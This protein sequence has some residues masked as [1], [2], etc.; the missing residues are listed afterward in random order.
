MCF[1]LLFAVML[2]S[3]LAVKLK[4]CNVENADIVPYHTS[5]QVFHKNVDLLL[6]YEKL[7]QTF[8]ITCFG[9][10][11]LVWKIPLIT[12]MLVEACLP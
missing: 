5:W 10:F 11:R 2:E 1:L 6:T 12:V 9:H 8:S 4:V 3:V 7:S